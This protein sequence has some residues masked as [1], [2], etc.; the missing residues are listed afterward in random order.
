MWLTLSTVFL[1]GLTVG[2]LTCLA[3]Q[4]G[5]LATIIQRSKNPIFSTGAF[6]TAKFGAYVTLGLLLGTFG[7]VISL[8]DKFQAWLQ[9]L[10]GL[11]MIAAALNLLEVHPIFRYTVIQPPKWITRIIKNQS[12]SEK[13]FAPAFLGAMTIFIPCGTTLAMEGLAISSTSPIKGAAIMGAFVLGTI[14]LFLGIGGLLTMLSG[15]LKRRFL[16]AAAVA[17]IFL[18]L[19]SVNGALVALN[20]PVSWNKFA[21]VFEPPQTNQT[22]NNNVEINVTSSGYSPNYIRVRK[23]EQVNLTI[24]AKNVYS[25][26]A[27]FR[28]PALGIVKNLGV[29]DSTVISFMPKEAGKIQFNCSMG[30]YR[31]II[32]V[33]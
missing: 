11:Y 30:M 8:G 6:L 16:F 19:T 13:I 4:G 9:L 21:E 17:I 33:I 18:G 23:G 25:C 3:V 1:T 15:V 10:A 5:L 12:R 22:I 27:A 31:G 26:A 20:S 7:N 24:K 14:P 28:I 32:E 2:G 29:N